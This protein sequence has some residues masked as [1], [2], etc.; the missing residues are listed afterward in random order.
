MNGD[1]ESVVDE[2]YQYDLFGPQEEDEEIQNGI[3]VIEAGKLNA[4][5]HSFIMH[6]DASQIPC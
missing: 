2:T 4:K 5:V 3:T 1:P 6:L